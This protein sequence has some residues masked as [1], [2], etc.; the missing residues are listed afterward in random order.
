[1]V[2]FPLL[3]LVLAF[4]LALVLAAFGGW[5]RQ[6]EWVLLGVLLAC[7]LLASLLGSVRLA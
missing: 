4:V 5:K 6:A 1:M 2:T 7:W 3:L